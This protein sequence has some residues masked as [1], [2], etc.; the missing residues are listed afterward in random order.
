VQLAS[1]KRWYLPAAILAVAGTALKIFQWYFSRPLWLDEQMVLLNIRDRAVSDLIGPLWLDQTAPLG[2]LV[3]Q[4]AVI[5]AFGTSDRAV[6]ALPVLFGIA[7]IWMGFWIAQRWMKPLAA[8]VFVVLCGIG[9]WLTY[10]ALEVKPYSADGLSALALPMLAVWAAEPAKDTPLSPRRTA[11]W[12]IVAAVAQWFSFGA[13]FVTPGCAVVLFTIAWRRAGWRPAAYVAAQGFIWFTC[14]ATHYALSIRYATNDEFLRNFWSWGFPPAGAGIAATLQ[15]L[16]KQAE[17]LASHPG[18]T[19]LWVLLWLTVA[20]G[21]GASLTKTPALG[22]V[23]LSVPLTAL[24]LAAFRQVPLADRLALWITPVLYAAIAFTVDDV[25]E[26]GR[27]ATSRSTW[28]AVAVAFAIAASLLCID[29]VE[30]GRS[31]LV[32]GGDNHALDDKRALRFLMSQRRP[33]D[34]LLTT[35]FG[36]PAVWWYGGIDIADPH[37]GSRFLQDG[38]PIFQ[39]RHVVFGVEGCR[40]RRPLT[41]L[42]DALAGA[43]RAAVYLG[44]DSNTPEGFQERVL[45]EVSRH[46]TLVAFRR[47]ASLGVAAIFDLGLPPQSTTELPSWPPGSLKQ[48][49]RPRGCVA[50]QLAKRW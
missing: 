36:L 19:S 30:R 16:G 18:G 49:R 22:L 46:G 14:F 8:A 38:A 31:N 39:V 10:Y 24:L 21:I 3:L 15:W 35:G 41:Q 43:S 20:Y 34:V 1:S 40:R 9:Q 4:H 47:I 12:W 11:I 44:F 45:D 23:L 26:R 42:E 27:R 48:V 50:V 6:R 17:P 28:T 7:T 29:I 25:F 32:V 5:N 37:L 33:G 2:W 13:T